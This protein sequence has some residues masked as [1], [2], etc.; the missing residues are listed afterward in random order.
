MA[1]NPHHHFASFFKEQKDL[2]PF[3]YA[4][5]K[6]L[7]EGS[8]CIDV[9]GSSE[10]LF[11]DYSDKE[12]EEEFSVAGLKKLQSLIGN[13]SNIKKPFV[14]HGN[15]FYITR[16]FNY[17]TQ[18]IEGIKSLIEK[19]AG[20]QGKRLDWLKGS[21]EFKKLLES[22]DGTMKTDWQL[23]ASAMAYL[24]NFT[25]ITGGPGTGKTT[26]VAKILSLLF[27][28]NPELEVKLAAPT[29]KAAMRMKES[30]SANKK[31]PERFREKINALNPYTL[32]RLL[33][34]KHLSP[35]F[36]HNR[37]NKLQADV[38]IV[39]EASMIDVALFAK[40]IDAVDPST[41]LI[42]LGDQ[43]QLTSVEAGSLLGDL[44][45]TVGAKN[46][47]SATTSNALEEILSATKLNPQ[48]EVESLLQDHVVELQHSYRFDRH[49]ALGAVSRSV[50]SNDQNAIQSWFEN[51]G[52]GENIQIDPNY[53]EEIFKDFIRNFETY[54][55]RNKKSS[56]EEI[57]ASLKKFNELR[58][59][60]VIKNGKQGVAGLNAAVEKNLSKKGLISTKSEFYDHRPVIVTKNHPDLQLFNGDIGL[61]R[62]DPDDDKKVKIWF[63]TEDQKADQ[64][65]PDKERPVVRGYSPGLLTDVE[66]VFAMTV[67]KSQG[68]EFKNV[69]LVMPKSEEV[70]ILTR[71]LLYTGITRAKKN[72]TIQG[73]KEVLLKSA[74][75]Q[76]KRA[77]GIANRL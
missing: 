50:I 16:Y 19:G 20:E 40:F 4:A 32:H 63:L 73:T 27:E 76:V 28:E 2:Q 60:A 11:E 58:I 42:I 46:Y 31:I 7:A 68:S 44:C 52:P 67:H 72:L 47:F 48:A 29:G 55:D 17:E 1:D 23:V 34:S 59:L 5:S 43:D 56:M 12:T 25:I 15:N 33:G 38:I 3:V 74:A 57:E 62:K 39:D 6:S 66:T 10:D 65:N 14:L 9:T 75:G 51:G 71:E 22:R 30:L 37:Q 41:R 45:N 35:Y 21:E 53:S 77:S 70:P 8:I 64:E 54:I 18:I 69:L 61:V 49:S 26:T 24:N 13:E 36:K